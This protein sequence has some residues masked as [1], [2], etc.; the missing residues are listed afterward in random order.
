MGAVQNCVLNVPSRRS[1]LEDVDHIRIPDNMTAGNHKT[2]DAS[3]AVTIDGSSYETQEGHVEDLVGSNS[4]KCAFCG[5]PLCSPS[6][7]VLEE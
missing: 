6:T 2:I 4:P 3:T 1:S 5:T 7:H